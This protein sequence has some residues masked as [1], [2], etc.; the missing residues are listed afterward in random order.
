MQDRR[1][2]PR[3]EVSAPLFARRAGGESALAR[4]AAVTGSLLNASRGG[5]AFLADEPVA[6]GELVAL[7]IR[8]EDGSA[9]LERYA[10]VIGCDAETEHGLV[11]RCAFIEPT[12][13]LDWVGALAVGRTAG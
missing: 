13:G 1:R 11:V 8:T 6:P 2:F 3:V 5:V 12:A 9:V 4:G 10:R 7:S